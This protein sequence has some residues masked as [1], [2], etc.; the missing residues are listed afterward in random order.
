MRLLSARVMPTAHCVWWPDCASAPSLFGGLVLVV[1]MMDLDGRLRERFSLG[2]IKLASA[3]YS[4]VL[5]VKR[6]PTS[7]M[8]IR[9]VSFV[10]VVLRRQSSRSLFPAARVSAGMLFTGLLAVE[11]SSRFFR[12]AMKLGSSVRRLSAMCRRVSRCKRRM[13]SGRKASLLLFANSSFRLRSMPRSAGSS[14]SWLL[15]TSR[16]CS[17]EMRTIESGREVMALLLT[18]RMRSAWKPVGS[19]RWWGRAVKARWVMRSSAER[20][21]N[22]SAN[23]LFCCTYWCTCTRDVWLGSY[24][25]SSCVTDRFER[26]PSSRIFSALLPNT[27]PRRFTSVM[28]QG[29]DSSQH[30][31]AT[32]ASW[33]AGANPPL[34]KSMECKPGL[35]RIA[36]ITRL[37]SLPVSA[38]PENVMLPRLSAHSPHSDVTMF[39]RCSARVLPPPLII[40]GVRSTLPSPNR[41]VSRSLVLSASAVT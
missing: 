11:T 23:A 9:Y 37:H 15:D 40:L 33:S 29:G 32:H 30:S 22:T 5:P 39:F 26:S 16:D 38:V 2:S 8:R 24:S 4:V 14:V 3:L 7:M 6:W 41:D 10:P 21:F 13:E 27:L 1:N 28:L 20:P 25:T 36:R 12:N 31:M 34:E 19:W 35:P 18:S 17:D